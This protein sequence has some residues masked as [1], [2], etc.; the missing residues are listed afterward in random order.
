VVMLALAMV[1][2]R[3]LEHV[4]GLYFAAGTALAAFMLLNGMVVPAAV[5]AISSAM[6]AIALLVFGGEVA[7]S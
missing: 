2:S 5:Q 7:E 6:G 1:L 4:A 3:K